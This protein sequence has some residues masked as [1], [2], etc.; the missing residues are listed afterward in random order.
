MWN[1]LIVNKFLKDVKINE[2]QLEKEIE[3]IKIQNEY[4]LSEIVFETTNIE[5]L[6]N[7]FERIKKEIITNGFSNA[8]IIYSISNTA[9]SG[10]DLGWISEGSLN[11]KIREQIK[12]TKKIS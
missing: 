9:N 3:S 1:S 2:K 5:N 4:L 10:G 7:K 11:N 8:A 12:K 6:E